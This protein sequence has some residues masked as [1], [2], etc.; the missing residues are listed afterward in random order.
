MST[1]NRQASTRKSRL[2][3]SRLALTFH[4]ASSV[5]ALAYATPSSCG[6]PPGVWQGRGPEPE[7]SQRTLAVLSSRD[8][9]V[10]KLEG[11]ERSYN[12]VQKEVLLTERTYADEL[13][14]TLSR[15]FEAVPKG[16]VPPVNSIFLKLSVLKLD[17]LP[18]VESLRVSPDA[19]PGQVNV[20][21]GDFFR[22]S[23]QVYSDDLAVATA[24]AADLEGRKIIYERL[25]KIETVCGFNPRRVA[26]L[27]KFVNPLDGKEFKRVFLHHDQ[28][29]DEMLDEKDGSFKGDKRLSE[30]RAISRLILKWMKDHQPAL[31]KGGS[32]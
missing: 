15:L 22:S 1:T 32:Q 26:I 23:E 8:E 31:K 18:P 3:G 10:L 5:A 24:V 13:R 21:G 14:N 20:R 25:K 16:A 9:I 11:L 28:I 30:G 17:E 27:V 29:W 2:I 12:S 6:D 4:I 7:A 19:G